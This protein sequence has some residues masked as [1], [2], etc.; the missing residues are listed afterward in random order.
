MFS[1]RNAVLSIIFHA[2]VSNDQAPQPERTDILDCLSFDGTGFT[3]HGSESFYR[4]SVMA[5]P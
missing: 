3:L 4:W 1:I 5:S 2:F